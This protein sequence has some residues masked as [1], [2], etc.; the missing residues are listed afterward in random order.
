MPHILTSFTPLAAAAL[1]VCSAGAAHAGDFLFQL[2]NDKVVD[3]D[4]HYT[5][6]VRI[7]YTMDAPFARVTDASQALTNML[8]FQDGGKL[9]TGWVLGQDMYTPEDVD[10]YVPDPTDRPYAGWLY[11]GLSGQQDDGYRQDTYEL[12]VGII[13]P[14]AKAGQ[15]QNSIHRAINVSVSRGWRSQIGHEIGVQATRMLKLRTQPS[16]IWGLDDTKY[17]FIGHGT[18]QLGNVRTGAALGGTVRLGGNLAEDFGPVYGIFALPHK[19]AKC[20]TWSVFLG[21]EARAVARDIF[22]DGNSFRN[23]PDVKKEPYVFEGRTGFAVQTPFDGKYWVT[24]ARFSVNM[25]Q[26]S[27]EFQAQNKA[28]RYGSVQ[29]SLNF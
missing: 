17:D 4:R 12:N 1:L 3:T 2:D 23:S 22:L 13:G 10:A 29:L 24:G 20:F 14:S 9:R 11:G 15:T 28:D 26:R 25:V 5:N 8:W 18:A 21:G 27:R 19:R 6:G 7:A 16:G